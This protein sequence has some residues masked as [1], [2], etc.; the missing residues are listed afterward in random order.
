ML[1][2]KGRLDKARQAK[3]IEELNQ[4][5]EK[6]RK[7]RVAPALEKRRKLAPADVGGDYDSD[8]DYAPTSSVESNGG[9]SLSAFTRNASKRAQGRQ[10]LAVGE[11]FRADAERS[12]CGSASNS[13][14]ALADQSVRKL[15]RLGSGMKVASK[16]GATQRRRS[17][18]ARGHGSDAVGQCQ[19]KT[20]RKSAGQDDQSDSASSLDRPLYRRRPAAQSSSAPQV[21]SS[22]IDRPRCD[23]GR[24]G[25]AHVADQQVPDQQTLNVTAPPPDGA[26]VELKWDPTIYKE[27]NGW[28]KAIVIATSHDGRLV[29]PGRDRVRRLVEKGFSI[30]QYVDDNSRFVHLLDE[31]HHVSKFGDKVDAWRLLSSPAACSADQPDRGAANGGEEG[32]SS[33][34]AAG[35]ARAR[36]G[37]AAPGAVDPAVT[38]PLLN[39]SSGARP[40]AKQLDGHAAVAQPKR[41]SENVWGRSFCFDVYKNLKPGQFRLG[42]AR[43]SAGHFNVIRQMPKQGGFP[44]EADITIY[45]TLTSKVCY[46]AYTEETGPTLFILSK[47]RKPKGTDWSNT[48]RGYQMFSTEEALSRVDAE[49]DTKHKGCAT[50]LGAKSLRYELTVDKARGRTTYHPTDWEV[51]MDVRCIVGMVRLAQDTQRDD[52]DR[53]MHSTWPAKTSLIFTGVAYSESHS[54]R[55]ELIPLARQSPR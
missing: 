26:T 4:A 51:S 48:L 35:G 32:G 25:V 18:A 34:T 23:Q 17:K 12:S 28:F 11:D 5:L 49:D 30:V 36:A 19:E 27:N 52:Y 54:E 15:K 29:A 41:K 55:G 9:C 40:A 2:K 20:T 45:V 38:Q 42:I 7:L 53:T 14:L 3:K 39:L 43:Y 33:G 22:D 16:A 6:R 47:L 24:Q 37:V 31:M 21:D 8:S 50:S 46:I 10:A 13:S 1:K 44:K